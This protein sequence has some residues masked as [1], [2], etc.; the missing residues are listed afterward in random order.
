MQ[1]L[2]VSTLDLVSAVS[3]L[4]LHIAANKE[5]SVAE[6][7]VLNTI[8]TINNLSYYNIS[9]SIIVAKQDFITERRD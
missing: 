4:Y 8:A 2:G 3:P 9:E 7:L 5:A 1:I 6:E